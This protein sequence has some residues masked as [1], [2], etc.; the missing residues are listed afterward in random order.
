MASLPRTRLQ[1]RL[2]VALAVV[3]GFVVSSRVAHVLSDLAH[4]AVSHGE[5][6]GPPPPPP[7]PPPPAPPAPPAPPPPPPAPPAPPTPFQ[8]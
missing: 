3:A 2:L 4:S 8:S 5:Y 7:P 1:K 6:A